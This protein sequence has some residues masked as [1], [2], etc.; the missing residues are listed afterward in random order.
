MCGFDSRQREV[1][2][3]GSSGF[4]MLHININLVRGGVDERV[5]VRVLYV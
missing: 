4:E 2:E 3:H 1:E 5:C